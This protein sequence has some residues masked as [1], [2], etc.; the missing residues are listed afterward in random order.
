MYEFDP[1]RIEKVEGLRAS[2]VTPYPHG[3]SVSHTTA[4]VVALIGDRDND[5]LKADETLVTVAGRLLFKNEMGKAGFARIQDRS[6]RIQIYIR[7]NDLGD[8]VFADV[9]VRMDVRA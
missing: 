6:G 2:G 3:L 4:Q 5:A 1:K 8:D 9:S 7:K